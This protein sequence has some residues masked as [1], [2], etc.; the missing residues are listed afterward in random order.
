LPPDVI[1]IDI[2]ATPDSS[3]EMARKI[4]RHLPS[5]GLVMLT[6]DVNDIQLF[7]VLKA[8]AS[9]YL[10]KEVSPEQ[11]AQT[12]QLVSSGEHPIN[13]SLA[14][15]PDIANQVL[16]QFQELSIRTETGHLISPLTER[17][18]NP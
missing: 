4:K 9:A 8:Q 17:D 3:L 11:L 7:Q 15:R 12:I 13:A 5:I 2:D 6:S 10:S 1:I 18:R 16:Q 14:D